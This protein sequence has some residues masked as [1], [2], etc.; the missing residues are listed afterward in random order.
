[1][2]RRDAEKAASDTQ[3]IVDAAETFLRSGKLEP[4]Q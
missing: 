1:V 2:T 3:A 4:F